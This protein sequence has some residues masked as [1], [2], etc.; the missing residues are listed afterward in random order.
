MPPHN[1]QAEQNLVNTLFSN[2]NTSYIQ[3]LSLEI[4]KTT[5]MLHILSAFIQQTTYFII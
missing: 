3:T 4:L 5:S 1:P 2:H